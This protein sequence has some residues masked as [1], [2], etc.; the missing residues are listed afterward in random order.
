MRGDIQWETIIYKNHIFPDPPPGTPAKMP[1]VLTDDETA[2]ASEYGPE[3]LRRALADGPPYNRRQR[4]AAERWIKKQTV[5]PG[6][7][8]EES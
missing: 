4:R 8:E 5:Q 2:F 3:P 7:G 1:K 6:D